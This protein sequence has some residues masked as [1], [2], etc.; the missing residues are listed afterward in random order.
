MGEK[1]ILTEKLIDEKLA[2]AA[3]REVRWIDPYKMAAWPLDLAIEMVG[4]GVGKKTIER[5]I[6]AGDLAGYK[7]GKETCVLPADFVVWF[8]RFRK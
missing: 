1:Q 6:S 3:S 8:K 5:A 7:P 4:G 2:A